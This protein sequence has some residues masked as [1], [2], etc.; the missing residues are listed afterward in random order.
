MSIIV[1]WIQPA[2]SEMFP[3]MSEPRARSFRASELKEALDFCQQQR[4]A[5]LRH[6][7]LSSENADSIGKPGVDSVVDGKTPDGHDYNW[8]KR[9]DQ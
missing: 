1:Y 5:G 2:T 8:M 6:V 4:A 9:R 3:N 7:S